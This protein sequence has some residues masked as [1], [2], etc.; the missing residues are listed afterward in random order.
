MGYVNPFVE[1]FS[2]FYFPKYGY[3]NKIKLPHCYTNNNEQL[4]TNPALFLSTFYFNSPV[5]HK[6]HVVKRLSDS[7]L[8]CLLIR[9]VLIANSI[10][11]Q[12]WKEE[13]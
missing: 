7:L 5:S 12:Y 3:N 9:R 11:G 10:W 2:I 8:G 13:E 4:Q 6:F 1:Y